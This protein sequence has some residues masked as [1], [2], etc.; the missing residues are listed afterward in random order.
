MSDRR[1]TGLESKDLEIFTLLTLCY[2]M[3]C[4]IFAAL[5]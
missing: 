3:T 5:K 4:F 1:E 2:K